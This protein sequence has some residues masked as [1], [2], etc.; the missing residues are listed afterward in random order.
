M[1]LVIE[2]GSQPVLLDLK[3]VAGLEIHPKP[4]RGPEITG[5]TKRRIRGDGTLALDDLVDAPRG[6]TDVLC[7]AVL[8]DPHG[9]EELLKQNLPGMDWIHSFR[10]DVTS[11]IVDDLNVVGVAVFPTET[12]SPPFVDPNAMLPSTSIRELLQAIAGRNPQVF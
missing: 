11:V 6:N 10:H 2:S 7:H 5:Q 3:I 1:D 8:A 9:D 4:L 12:D